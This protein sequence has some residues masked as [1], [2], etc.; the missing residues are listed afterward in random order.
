[1]FLAGIGILHA[2]LALGTLQK[3]HPFDQH[4][5]PFLPT[6][7][8]MATKVTHT[9]S[10]TESDHHLN[11]GTLLSS[12][13]TRHSEQRRSSSPTSDDSDSSFAADQEGVPLQQLSKKKKKKSRSRNLGPGFRPQSQGNGSDSE[14]NVLYNRRSHEDGDE[15]GLVVRWSQ[16][17]GSPR[18]LNKLREKHRRRT[19]RNRRGN[20]DEDRIPG[21]LL[22]TPEEERR[23]VR[24]MDKYLVG[25]LAGLY[26]LSFLD[27]SNA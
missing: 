27:R 4:T 9:V 17:G 11:A 13:P 25:F 1:M 22:F 12:P 23:V 5:P 26:M 6:I 18:S 14:E 15:G 3:H 10:D 19:G 24:K 20:G 16:D 7:T 21:D 8:V 2:P